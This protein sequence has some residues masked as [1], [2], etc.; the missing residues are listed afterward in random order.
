VLTPTARLLE[1]LELLQAKPLITGR[2][3]SDRLEIDPRTVRRYVEALQQLGIPVEG[4]ARRRR[5][6]PHPAGATDFRP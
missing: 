2:E 5:G 1:F 6:L 4:P 3:I